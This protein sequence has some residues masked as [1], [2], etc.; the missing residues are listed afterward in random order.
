MKKSGLR[1]VGLSV[2]GEALRRWCE[3]PEGSDHFVGDS[4]DSELRPEVL[5]RLLKD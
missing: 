4:D 2:P 3:G 5:G 1:S